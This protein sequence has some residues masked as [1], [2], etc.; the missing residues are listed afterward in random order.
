MLSTWF[1]MNKT[2]SYDFSVVIAMIVLLLILDITLMIWA[3]YCL[4]DCYNN[5]LISLPVAV[6]LGFLLFVPAFGIIVPI[7]I[8]VYHSVYCKHNASGKALP[9]ASALPPATFTFY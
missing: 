3:F 8:I 4:V 1:A 2:G 7:G 6:I 9:T 5:K